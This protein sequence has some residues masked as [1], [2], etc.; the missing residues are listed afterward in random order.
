MALYKESPN[1][2]VFSKKR[3]FGEISDF[4]YSIQLINGHS[5]DMCALTR[6]MLPKTY[7]TI[8]STNNTLILGEIGV[9]VTVTVPDG[10]YNSVNF[11][12]ILKGLLEAASPNNLG[13]EV[14]FIELTKK[15]T[16][17]CYGTTGSVSITFSSRLSNIMGFADNSAYAFTYQGSSIW[18]LTSVKSVN[19]QRTQFISLASDI[20]TND[21]ANDKDGNIFVRIPVENAADGE[22]IVYELK[23]IQDQSRV[24]TS[25]NGGSF[26]FT[27][28]DD[29]GQ[30]L[31]LL[32]DY[33]FDIF[34]Y[35][36]NYYSALR[37][38]QIEDEQAKLK[39]TEQDLNLIA[40]EQEQV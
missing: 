32:N 23:D 17:T 28:F 4:G 8:S 16:I 29:Q 20:A 2:T 6:L 9:F 14:T 21:G 40:L 12:G 19:F 33:N 3:N 15:L 5:Y 30:I 25:Q 37:I 10:Y 34:F 31:T 35:Q 11:P 7:Y 24:L 27:L 22:M 39:R 13:Y 38:Q 1:F 26:R 36:F 18:T